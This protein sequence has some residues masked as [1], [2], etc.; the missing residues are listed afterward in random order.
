MIQGT[1]DVSIDTPKLHRRGTLA[2]KSEGERIVAR[3]A[4][5]DLEPIDFVGTCK[6]KTFH[7]EGSGEL[8]SL[9]QVDY[10][11]DGEVWGNSIDV[12]CTTTAGNVTLF[13]TRLSGSAG[14]L[15]SSHEYMMSAS[16]GDVISNDSAMYSGLYADG[17]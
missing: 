17:G 16:T 10:Q 13:G 11:A 8:P 4:V 3:L 9:G 12:K 14:D 15:K 2:L 6:D 5:T 1:F 7:I